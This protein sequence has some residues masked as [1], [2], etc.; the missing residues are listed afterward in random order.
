M[1]VAIIL[2]ATWGGSASAV[3]PQNWT[4]Q[5]QSDY[6][7]GQ[8]DNVVVDNFGT[9][10]LGRQLKEILID[11]EISFVNSFAQTPDGKVY[12][13][14]SPEGA[15]Y[16]INKDAAELYFAAPEAQDQVLSLAVN[17]QGHLL[18]AVC[19]EGAKL[20]ELTPPTKADE[21]PVTK[22]L[23]TQETVDYIWAIKETPDGSIYLGTG[24][25]GQVWKIAPDGKASVVLDTT[26]KN[27]LAL[28]FDKAGNLLAGTD[29]RG[30]VLRL[31]A[32]TQ[33]SFVLLDAGD[34]DVSALVPD[35]LGN[36]YVATA[37][38][39]GDGGGTDGDMD[40]G[41]QK[42]S[43]P[44]T[45]E[46]EP[47]EPMNADDGAPPTTH[48]T[49]GPATT[50]PANNPGVRNGKPTPAE[51]KGGKAAPQP[52]A[53]GTTVESG[54]L[55]V[56]PVSMPLSLEKLKL[57][58]IP[59]TPTAQR[60]PGRSRLHSP[61]TSRGMDKKRGM[62]MPG[63][64]DEEDEAGNTVYKITPEGKVVPVLH[65][66]ETLLSMLWQQDHLL[67]GTGTEGK[68]YTLGPETDDQT[69][70]GRV[71][72][73]NIMS[74]F[75]AKDG[76]V[77]GGMSNPGTVF[78]LSAANANKGTFTSAVLD[79][80]HSA[81]WGTATLS[82]T[83]PAGAKATLAVRTGNVREVKKQA[84]FWSDWSKEIPVETTGARAGVK[85]DLPPAR[86][87]QYRLSLAANDQGLSPQVQEVQISYQV[88]NL[89]PQIH[90]ITVDVGGD[91]APEK[92]SPPI[93]IMN[94]KGGSSKG[95]KMG[96]GGPEKPEANDHSVKI[97]W[98]VSDPNQDELVYR[99]YYRAVGSDLWLP[100]AKDLKDSEYEWATQAIP[101][102]KYQVKVTA[103]DSPDNP[104]SE[105]K[106]VA[107]ISTPFLI[108]NNPPALVDLKTSTEAAAGGG[109]VTLTGTAKSKLVA[110]TEVR[111][112]IDNQGDW[113]P[114]S[115]SDKMFD[116]PTEGFTLTTRN[117]AS[118]AHSITVRA[119]DAAGNMGYQTVTVNLP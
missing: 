41:H 81:S 83:I 23:F 3:H 18:V 45:F 51:K 47:D 84:K 35:A 29:S 54:I 34:V 103:S 42:T 109:K 96:G 27:V 52:G 12:F 118:G 100:L 55:A 111:F 99:L 14:T 93:H 97:S 94:G 80:K 69:L 62:N 16:V 98:D 59:A 88:E 71:D 68:L 32:Q 106:S 5:V 78:T 74:L 22:T 43:H 10:A 50:A 17:K 115:A 116:S 65:S 117:L 113:Q 13:S 36:I 53:Q 67:L 19:G 48:P 75:A 9:L 15:V 20:L 33:K 25:K 91:S 21:P 30:L 92:N 44:T 4:H 82:G 72:S 105:T 112:Q 73:E 39:K 11:D 58:M 60:K 6:I 110:V 90:D 57:S 77:Y 119:T 56:N 63:R 87:L 61:L 66:S 89:S 70:I 101:E 86:Y 8:F 104:P 31:D 2:A 102:G 107:R 114:A 46:A 64:P 1:S 24:P 40:T 95:P 38:P 28:A 7:E 85:I 108:V 26:A 76:T 37:T 79:A 49:T